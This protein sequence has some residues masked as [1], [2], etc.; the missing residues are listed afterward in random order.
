MR[1]G[2]G[3]RYDTLCCIDEGGEPCFGRSFVKT[4]SPYNH[5]K[6]STLSLEHSESLGTM[7]NRFDIGRIALFSLLC[8]RC[9]VRIRQHV[10]I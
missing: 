4:F 8:A 1:R 3:M 10:C 9:H 6:K 5:N 7:L 2:R